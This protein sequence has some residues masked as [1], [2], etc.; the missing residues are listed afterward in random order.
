[1]EQRTHGGPGKVAMKKGGKRLDS[2]AKGNF[3]EKKKG[4]HLKDGGRWVSTFVKKGE[5][6][7]QEN[8]HKETPGRIRKKCT[9]L[10][11]APKHGKRAERPQRGVKRGRM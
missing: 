2:G 10:Q 6:N 11:A 3:K 8:L 4:K 5:G 1:M 9:G 7:K